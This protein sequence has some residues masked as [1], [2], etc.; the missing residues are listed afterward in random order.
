MSD[1]PNGQQPQGA[2]PGGF[3]PQVVPIQPVGVAYTVELARGFGPN[4]EPV[5]FVQLTFYTATGQQHYF[6]PT[7]YAKK[8]AETIAAA[9]SGLVIPNSPIRD[10]N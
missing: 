10:L 4:G 1:I 2:P 8:L 9:A 3:L 5:T 6:W 7:Q